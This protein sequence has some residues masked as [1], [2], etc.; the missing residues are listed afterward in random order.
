MARVVSIVQLELKPGVTDDQVRALAVDIV[1]DYKIPG[2]INPRIA[3]ADRGD[4]DG[5]YVFI[6]EFESV[7]TRARYWPE[8]GRSSAEWKR[9]TAGAPAAI[10]ER[11]SSLFDASVTD[12]VVL[13]E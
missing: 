3:K 10:A 11:F 12:Y 9:N 6:W 5:K 13:G 4:R 8:W 1:R 7:E 2:V